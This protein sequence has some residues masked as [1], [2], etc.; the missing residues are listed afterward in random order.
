MEKREIEKNHVKFAQGSGQPI[1]GDSTAINLTP[2]V[3][4]EATETDAIHEEVRHMGKFDPTKTLKTS[5]PTKIDVNGANF[6]YSR[7]G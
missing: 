4:S 1:S 6:W 7:D 2:F 5:A 3:E